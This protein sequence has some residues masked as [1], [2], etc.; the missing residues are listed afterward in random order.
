M[1]RKK[2]RVFEA[3]SFVYLGFVT[4]AS[5]QISVA[6]EHPAAVRGGVLAIPLQR[7][8]ASDA[9]P[10]R[11]EIQ[12][13]GGG[14]VFDGVVAWIG[15]KQ[16]PLSRTW[17][18]SQEQLDIRPIANAPTETDP[19]KSGA[20]VLLAK[21]PRDISGALRVANSNV[22]P[23]W[24]ELAEVEPD[25]AKLPLS[26]QAPYALPDPTAPSE[27]FRWWLL[28]DQADRK[29]PPPAGDEIQ[30]LFALHRAQLWQAGIERMERQSPGVAAEIRERLTAVCV[31]TG[32]NKPDSARA[33]WIANADSLAALLSN[34]ISADRTDEQAMQSSLTLI[35]GISP[36]TIWPEADDGRGIRFAACNASPEEIVVQFAW[37]EAPSLASLAMLLPANGVAHITIDRPAELLHD[38]ITG[39]PSPTVGSL[40]LTWQ[41][42]SIRLSVAPEKNILRPPGY[43]FGLFL[44][45]LSLAD[46]QTGKIQPVPAAWSTT[47][48]VR[49]K[50]GHW[51]IFAE[52]LRQDVRLEDELDFRIGDSDRQMARIR[53]GEAGVRNVDST[54]SG[55]APEVRTD[56]FVDRWRCVVEIPEEWL[57]ADA[58]GRPLVIGISRFTNGPESRQ[59]AIAAATPWS[60]GPPL[61]LLEASKWI[62]PPVKRV[63]TSP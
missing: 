11:L 14:P 63:I 16:I 2:M 49:R 30:R 50:F 47:A 45:T 9:W 15:A 58:N 20:V 12:P 10:A 18:Q 29:P 21:S 19:E 22:D 39:E 53:V 36:V 40:L 24:L 7:Q 59:T 32:A 37:V 56:S 31:E 43:S 1:M 55:A 17:T 38:P 26:L 6:M 23:T 13:S 25:P 42:N 60:V 57:P 33:S 48:S 54:S 51:E 52:C 44:P 41:G 61:I 5:A 8:S 35:R 3:L 62:D 27:W 4:V 34:L 28:A 46:A